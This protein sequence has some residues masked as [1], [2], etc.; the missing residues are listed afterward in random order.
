[1]GQILRDVESKFARVRHKLGQIFET[2]QS[3]HGILN[4][5][6]PVSLQNIKNHI[7]KDINR[8]F[9]ERPF[10]CNESGKSVLNKL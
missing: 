1:M 2:W 5:Y 9:P 10:K 8:K 7:Q 3:K 4:V 6:L